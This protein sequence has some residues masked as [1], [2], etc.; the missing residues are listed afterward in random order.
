[1]STSA[2]VER[3]ALGF[4][5]SGEPLSF[6]DAFD[7]VRHARSAGDLADRALAALVALH[8]H[9]ATTDGGRA[10]VADYLRA[11]AQRQHK[12]R[13]LAGR[14]LTAR[15]DG[16][17]VRAPVGS[18]LLLSVADATLTA[19]AWSVTS[20]VGP[21]RLTRLSPARATELHADFGLELTDPGTVAVELAA[22]ADAPQGA[23]PA[24]RRLRLVIAVER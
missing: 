12:E 22:K 6:Y 16:R 4:V 7:V 21:A 5:D 24:P 17:T 3:L 2:D 18:T 14:V 9:P 11:Y 20:L 10:V 15:D 1:M 19:D 8:D 13:A 23:R